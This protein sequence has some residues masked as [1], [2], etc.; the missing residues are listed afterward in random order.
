MIRLDWEQ[1]LDN[2]DGSEDL[3]LELAKLFIETSSDMLAQI[4]TAIANGDAPGLHRAA[5]NLKGSARIFAAGEAVEQAMRL[6]VMGADGDLSQA[7]ECFA[8]LELTI[9]QLV[10]ALA[11]RIGRAGAGQRKGL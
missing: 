3:L 6:E 11:E 5:H 2:V 4:S 10:E 1:A 7:E 9:T 8:S